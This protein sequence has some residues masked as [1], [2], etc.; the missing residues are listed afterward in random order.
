MLVDS[1]CTRTRAEASRGADLEVC[2]VSSGTRA[3]KPRGACCL[4]PALAGS[5]HAGL[6][7]LEAG[8]LVEWQNCASEALSDP[9]QGCVPSF[10]RLEHVST[11]V[12]ARCRVR[13][14]SRALGLSSQDAGCALEAGHLVE[15]QI[16]NTAALAWCPKWEA[17]VITAQLRMEHGSMCMAHRCYLS[18]FRKF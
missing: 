6:C 14:R 16:S 9:W 11:A 5:Q 10:I 7:A 18:E 4:L 17:T 8:R 2:G 1:P 13:A 12:L 15:W 3:G